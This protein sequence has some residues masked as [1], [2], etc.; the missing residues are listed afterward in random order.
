MYKLNKPDVYHN[1]LPLKGVIRRDDEYTFCDVT[2][3]IVDVGV[4]F[5]DIISL[6]SGASKIFG[7]NNINRS[8]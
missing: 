3:L 5:I 4:L 6:S 7:F 2:E 8:V 1:T